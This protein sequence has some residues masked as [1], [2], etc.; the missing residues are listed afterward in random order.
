MLLCGEGGDEVLWPST[1]LSLSRRMPTW[2]LAG[3]VA[4]SIVLHRCRPPAGLRDRLRQ[5]RRSASEAPAFPTW[6][7]PVFAAN[8]DLHDRWRHFNAP[9]TVADAPL[10]AEAHGRLET[11]PWSWYF[12]FS[13]PGVTRIPVE[14]RYPFLD[15]RLVGSV[16]A[17]PPLPWSDR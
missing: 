15:V 4:R 7:D 9:E 13:D 6:L 11:G 17:M 16:L 10:R 5:W 3:E 1:V 2:K 8:L 12:E 14:T